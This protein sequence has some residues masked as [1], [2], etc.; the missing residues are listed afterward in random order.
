MMVGLKDHVLKSEKRV[1]VGQNSSIPTPLGK[2]PRR[3]R[4]QEDQLNE[5]NYLHPK[6]P[7]TRMS[8]ITYSPFTD[9]SHRVKTNQS[10]MTLM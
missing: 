3:N 8:I 7:S 9:I 6:K 1:S 10:W 2:L 5:T 4:E